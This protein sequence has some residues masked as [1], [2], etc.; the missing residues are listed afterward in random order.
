MAGK[1]LCLVVVCTPILG[2][3]IPQDEQVIPELPKKRNSPLRIV[4]QFP[5]GPATTF[6]SSST[7]R[8][9][10]KGFNLTIVD[11]DVG[12]T[13]RSRWFIDKS[14]NT[15]PY[16]PSARP[17]GAAQRIV[18]AP[19]SASFA[20]ELSNLASGTTHLLTVYVTDSSFEEV[21]N[22]LIAVSRTP[23]VLPDGGTITDRAFLD[24]FTWVL[25]I[26]GETCQ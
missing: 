20:N 6:Y 3:L 7:C 25:T 13:I 18:E 10:N 15:V 11:E 21:I 2:C 8:D 19:I 12:D 17:P 24:S 9:R 23:E 4:S 5:E 16:E 22:G 26:N 1:L 14:I